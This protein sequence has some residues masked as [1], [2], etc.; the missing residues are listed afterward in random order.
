MWV[1]RTCRGAPQIQS[2]GQCWEKTEAARAGLTTIQGNLQETVLLL[3]GP[4]LEVSFLICFC[5]TTTAG[6]N[7]QRQDCV[8]NQLSMKWE[9]KTRLTA[10]GISSSRSWWNW[11]TWGIEDAA[12]RKARWPRL[13]GVGRCILGE[14]RA[15]S[16]EI[17][18]PAPPATAWPDWESS[19]SPNP[20]TWDQKEKGK[21][22]SLWLT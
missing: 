14:R 5:F 1:T 21:R 20:G 22:D 2:A 6:H 19:H 4:S 12:V 11:R 3:S 13:C 16:A 10:E 18:F 17:L 9:C 15:V 7:R 8:K